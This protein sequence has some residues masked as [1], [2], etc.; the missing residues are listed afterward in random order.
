[1]PSPSVAIVSQAAI[2]SGGPSQDLTVSG[3]GTPKAAMVF[4]SFA[5]ADGTPATTRA[6]LGIGATDGTRQGTVVTR[7]VDN[8]AMPAS[9]SY[10]STFDAN[11]NIIRTTS[12]ADGS[13][14]GLGAA[15]LITDGVRITWSDLPPSA[16]LIKA[17]LFGGP[18]ITQAYCDKWDSGL[19]VGAGDDVTEPGFTPDLVF[20]FGDGFGPNNSDTSG[21]ANIGLGFCVNDGSNTQRGLT[22][23]ETG[24]VN[25]TAV[26]QDLSTASAYVHALAGALPESRVEDFDANGFSVIARVNGGSG[27]EGFYLALKFSGGI[28]AKVMTGDSPTSTGDHTINGVGFTPQFAMILQG[29][30]TATD[31]QVADANSEAIAYSA[32]TATA[33]FSIGIHTDDNVATSNCESTVHNK[34]ISMRKDSATFMEGDFSAFTSDGMTINYTTAN[35]TVRK[36]AALFIQASPASNESTGRGILRGV[37]RG[38]R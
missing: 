16:Y 2:T 36:R 17:I 12:N 8:V 21:T 9:G 20:L 34:A 11:A 25:P 18:N 5:T 1:M 23:G 29:S 28:T 37:L 33:Q 24:N 32:I 19:T 14:D 6:M 13:T 7:H 30:V 15:S 35:G 31:S 3:F 22:M 27:L 38:G 4:Y 26:A 10:L